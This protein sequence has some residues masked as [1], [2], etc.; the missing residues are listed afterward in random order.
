LGLLGSTVSRTPAA[1]NRLARKAALAQLLAG[2]VVAVA[3]GA[4]Y[5][6]PAVAAA[7]SGAAAVALGTFLMGRA[8]LGG[9]VSTA[10]GALMRLVVGVFAKWVLVLALGVLAIGVLKLPPLPLLA[11]LVAALA[12]SAVLALQRR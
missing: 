1:T 4:L 8:L 11:G 9:G 5:G 12:A 2:A 6:P 7:M 10:T 3:L